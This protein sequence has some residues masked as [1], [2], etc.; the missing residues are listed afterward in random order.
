LILLYISSFIIKKK[1]L[2]VNKIKEMCVRKEGAK[3]YFIPFFY[4]FCSKE[5][6]LKGLGVGA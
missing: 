5:G 2:D 3:K 1:I 6:I 4:F